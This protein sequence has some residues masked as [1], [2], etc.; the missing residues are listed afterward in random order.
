MRTIEV[1]VYKFDELSDKAKERARDWWLQCEMSEDWWRDVYAD[2]DE[3][4]KFIGIEMDRKPVKLMGG[5]TRYDPCIWFNGFSSQGDGACFEGTYSYAKGSVKKIRDEFPTDTTLHGI[6]DGLYELQ[7][8][9]G[10][11][12]SARVDHTGHYYHSGCTSFEV[13]GLKE[14]DQAGYDELK[15]LLRDFMDWIYKNLEDDHDYRT[16]DE[17]VDDAITANEYEFDESGDIHV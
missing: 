13:D 4:A 7:R 3:T 16:D 17:Y 6:V 10:F 15:T 2:V 14:D 1:K 12:V 11:K 9:R 8:K 5:G